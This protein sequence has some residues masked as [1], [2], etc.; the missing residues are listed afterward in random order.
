M[1]GQIRMAERDLENVKG[2]LPFQVGDPVDVSEGQI[3]ATIEDV[4]VTQ[5]SLAAVTNV[6][7]PTLDQLIQRLTYPRRWRRRL[8]KDERRLP[9]KVVRKSPAAARSPMPSNGANQTYGTA[10]GKFGDVP[11]DDSCFY[12]CVL[13]H[14]VSDP[15][16]ATDDQS[17]K[18]IGRNTSD[19]RKNIKM[20][21]EGKSDQTAFEDVDVTAKKRCVRPH[22]GLGNPKKRC[23]PSQFPLS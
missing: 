15:D 12:H 23:M 3:V 1:Q 8:N 2:S 18:L 11:G 14:I 4:T 5:E 10:R 7:R 13:T 22:D 9:N 21:C 19:M 17:L 16:L 20:I 6:G